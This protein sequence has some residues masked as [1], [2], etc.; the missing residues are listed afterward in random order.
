MSKDGLG[1]GPASGLPAQS[2]SR[3]G[4]EALQESGGSEVETDRDSFRDILG[5]VASSAAPAGTPHGASLEQSSAAQSATE[6][7]S[8]SVNHAGVLLSEERTTSAAAAHAPTAGMCMHSADKPAEVL[9]PA[10]PLALVAPAPA[11]DALSEVPD[12]VRRPLPAAHAPTAGTANDSAELRL[13]AALA[14]AFARAASAAAAPVSSATFAPAEL[15]APAVLASALSSA[16][17]TASDLAGPASAPANLPAPASRPPPLLG[18]S[19]KVCVDITDHYY[20]QLH[21]VVES[22]LHAI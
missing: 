8:S 16:P 17:A 9:A 13:P 6:E 3:A 21:Q 5:E 12:P 2:Q 22:Y 14:P 10:E 4:V 11:S 1:H 15:L 18:V 19:Q 20:G 7:P